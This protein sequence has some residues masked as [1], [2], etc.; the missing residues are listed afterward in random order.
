[1]WEKNSKSLDVHLGACGGIVTVTAKHDTK[2]KAMLHK[3]AFHCIYF[4]WG[5]LCGPHVSGEHTCSGSLSFSTGWH[6]QL[7]QKWS[8]LMDKPHRPRKW[9]KTIQGGPSK[10]TANHWFP[11]CK[12]HLSKS[13][14]PKPGHCSQEQQGHGTNPPSHLHVVTLK[15]GK[16][17]P[18]IMIHRPQWGEPEA[19]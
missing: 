10:E 14:K 8:C 11:G 5:G 16:T 2:N 7:S 6:P 15:C 19:T 12:G 17:C 1:M 18:R 13:L 3:H 4:P 9:Q